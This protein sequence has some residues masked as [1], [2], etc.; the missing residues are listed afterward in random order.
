MTRASVH[1]RPACIFFLPQGWWWPCGWR[2]LYQGRKAHP[3]VP[4]IKE[5]PGSP[6]PAHPLC[7]LPIKAPASFTCCVSI[8]PSPA[9]L[10]LRGFA[11]LLDDLSVVMQRQHSVLRLRRP[12]SSLSLLSFTTTTHFPV[13]VLLLEVFCSI[14]NHISVNL[15]RFNIV[16]LL[17]NKAKIQQANKATSSLYKK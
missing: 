15:W 10:P 16:H 2:M 8:F 5:R 3:F 9:C 1:R 14:K 7:P 17:W 4:L 12:P 13:V 11:C 6:P